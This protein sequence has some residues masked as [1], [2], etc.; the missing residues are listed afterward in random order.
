MTEEF[1][2]PSHQERWIRMPTKPGER[3]AN[4]GLSR[5]HFYQLINAG[6]IKSASL[7]KKGTLK[8]VRLIWLP[9]VLEYIE[10]NV[11]KA[12]EVDQ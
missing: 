2:V 1:V 3:E 8:G 5:A 12:P 7:K 10:R 4:T 6:K 11:V 9:S